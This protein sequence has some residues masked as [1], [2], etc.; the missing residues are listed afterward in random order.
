MVLTLPPLIVVVPFTVKL[1]PDT[2]A[3]NVTPEAVKVVAAPKL[4][5][6]PKL[7]V[8]EVRTEPPLIATVPVASVVRLVKA[9]APP[10]APVNMVAPDVLTTRVL[11]PFKVLPNVM[12]PEAVLL[13]VVLTPKIT[14]P[15]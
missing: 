10:T 4:S 13:S 6:S 14:A 3:S 11:S 8:P 15:L 12:S 2:A 1:V 9:V 7:C 5:N